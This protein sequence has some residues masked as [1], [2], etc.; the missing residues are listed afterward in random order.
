[1]VV[2]RKQGKVRIG[3]LPAV[4]GGRKQREKESVDGITSNNGWSNITVM[5][6]MG[7]SNSADTAL[8]HDR[9]DVITTRVVLSSF[10]LSFNSLL[11]LLPR[12]ITPN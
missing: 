11:P 8:G 6:Y 10:I 7:I 12:T 3:S 2:E 1:M 4:I 5:E 9:L